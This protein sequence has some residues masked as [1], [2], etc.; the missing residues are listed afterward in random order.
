MAI[1]TNKHTT[2]VAKDAT[3]TPI[4][5]NYSGG[6]GNFV[7]DPLQAGCVE[8]TAVYS[9]G[10]FVELVEGQQQSIGFSLE[11]YMDG[12]FTGG[13]GSTASPADMPLKQGDYLTAG[14][15]RDPGGVVWTGDLVVTMTRN[16]VTSICTLTNGRFTV[17]NTEDPGGN[18]IAINGTAYGTGSTLACVW[19]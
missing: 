8:A 7:H 9:R 13:A 10:T 5:K 16:G 4:T 6:V 18:K 11:L 15:T 1:F 17:Q 2:I 12:K 3:G 14:T 19:S